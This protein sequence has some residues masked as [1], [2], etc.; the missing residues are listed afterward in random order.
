MDYLVAARS[1][2]IGAAC[3]AAQNLSGQEVWIE[4]DGTV[5][6]VPPGQTVTL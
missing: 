4:V 6:R 1:L 3:S 2:R 5:V